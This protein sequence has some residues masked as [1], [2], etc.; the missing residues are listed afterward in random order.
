MKITIHKFEFKE[1]VDGDNP[2]EQICK[3][4][5]IKNPEK[6]DSITFDREYTTFHY[7][8]EIKPLDAQEVKERVLPFIKQNS[9]SDG[10]LS[11]STLEKNFTNEEIELMFET[12]FIYEPVIGTVK[13][14]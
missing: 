4:M 9:D 7:E 1:K 5:Q 2:F 3:E 8:E 14:T 12:G 11:T 6:V 10:E 13:A